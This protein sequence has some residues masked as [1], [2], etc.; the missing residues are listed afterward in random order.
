MFLFLFSRFVLDVYVNYKCIY[1]RFDL[2]LVF[3]YSANYLWVE[4][5]ILSPD[6]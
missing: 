5:F 2:V 6:L 4:G 3:N 1:K